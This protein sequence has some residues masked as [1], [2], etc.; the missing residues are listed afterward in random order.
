[1]RF[2]YL[3]SEYVHEVKQSGRLIRN[4]VRVGVSALCLT[5]TVFGECVCVCPVP[6]SFQWIEYIYGTQS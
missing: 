2:G 1:M 3:Y 4:T 5:L 6:F